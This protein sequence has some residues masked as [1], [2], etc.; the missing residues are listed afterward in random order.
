MA[1][2]YS[3]IKQI[4]KSISFKFILCFLFICLMSCTEV[5][6]QPPR[7]VEISREMTVVIDGKVF[8][9]QESYEPFS[10][11]NGNTHCNTIFVNTIL[12]PYGEEGYSD[13][14]DNYAR[15]E[16][17]FNKFGHLEDAKLWESP[18]GSGS[19]KHFVSARLNPEKYL[20]ISDYNYNPITNDISFS[21]EG[22]LFRQEQGTSDTLRTI[23]GHITMESMLDLECNQELDRKY[24][25]YESDSFN[26]Y[27]NWSRVGRV[28]ESLDYFYYFR[29]SY[30][31]SLS[32]MNENDLWDYPV[33]TS[34]NFNENSQTNKIFLNEYVGH[35]LPIMN[36]GPSEFFWKNYTTSGN[37]EILEKIEIGT[38]K[39][40]VGEI[41]MDVFEND[42]FLFSIQNMTFSTEAY[43]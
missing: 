9:Y 26:F 43:E 1:F 31:F 21:F 4:M 39:V 23:S 32:I 16:F 42:Q 17:D 18:P 14:E 24:I 8:E 6:E 27:S 22:T 10:H 30:G 41:N 38:Q 3:K 5:T 7:P 36:Q 19:F 33:G 20:K 25:K 40:I 28:N 37:Y 34:F 35:P 29:S 11:L 2:F 13:K 15:F 12:E